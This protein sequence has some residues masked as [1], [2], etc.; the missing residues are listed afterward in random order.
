MS[1]GS[2]PGIHNS[3]GK[4]AVDLAATH[5][6]TKVFNEELLQAAAQSKYINN[7]TLNPEQYSSKAIH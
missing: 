1:S 4:T 3:Y 2:D 7:L 5:N 6:I